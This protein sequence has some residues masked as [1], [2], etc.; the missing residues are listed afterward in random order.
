[1]IQDFLKFGHG[2]LSTSCCQVRLSPYIYGIEASEL[3]EERC[4]GHGEIVW[5][6]PLQPLDR[7]QRSTMSE[8]GKS[9]QRGKILELHW[10]ILRKAFLH[11]GREPLRFRKVA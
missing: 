6:R 2:L 9:M 8:C 4:A 3:V 5:N 7:V 11:V 10:G 1:M